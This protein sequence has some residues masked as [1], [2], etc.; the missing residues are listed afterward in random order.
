[1]TFIL[2]FHTK[3]LKSGVYFAL[4]AHS[5]FSVARGC[6]VGQPK[7][8]RVKNGFDAEGSIDRTSGKGKQDGHVTHPYS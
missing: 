5:H 6:A 1:M 7:P 3:N 8:G 2:C 4:R